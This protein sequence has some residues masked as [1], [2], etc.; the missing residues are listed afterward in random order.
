MP[1]SGRLGFV[2]ICAF[3]RVAQ[4]TCCL[5]SAEQEAVVVI[6]L[7]SHATQTTRCLGYPRCFRP[8]RLKFKLVWPRPE[9]WRIRLQIQE[10]AVM[11]GAWKPRPKTRMRRGDYDNS[12]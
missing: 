1:G 10:P 2:I 8:T 3:S 6:F 12:L 4:T 11:L 7:L 5:G 9:F